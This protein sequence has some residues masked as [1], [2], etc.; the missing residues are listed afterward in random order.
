[1][2]KKIESVLFPDKDGQEILKDFEASLRLSHITSSSFDD[3]VE[4]NL[5][6]HGRL[7]QLI[8]PLDYPY[9]LFYSFS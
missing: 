6:K 8:F 2:K 4:S 1:M 7:H 5:D 3:I 9:S